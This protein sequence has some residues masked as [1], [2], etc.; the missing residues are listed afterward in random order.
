MNFNRQIIQ[1]I[2]KVCTIGSLAMLSFTI[3]N[4]EASAGDFKWEY[5]GIASTGEQVNLDLNSISVAAHSLGFDPPASYFFTYQIGS[6][7]VTAIT[8]CSGT[9]SPFKNGYSD[10]FRKP[11]SKAMQK[12]L[13]RVCTYAVKRVRVFAPPSNVRAY[14]NGPIICT[15][16]NAKTITIYGIYTY[17]E[18]ANWQY[19]N[20][21]GKI[22]VIDSSQ[23]R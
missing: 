22:G 9:F 19:T 23:F 13:D 4:P 5:Q 2:S 17:G 10:S 6:D 15:I 3:A 21:C 7:R 20:A 14:P 8:G 1:S 18:K 11:Q 12:T 16:Q